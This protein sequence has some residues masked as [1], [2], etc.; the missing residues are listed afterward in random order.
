MKKILVPIDFSPESEKALKYATLLAHQ[1]NAQQ[2]ALYVVED[3]LREGILAH[4]FPPEGYSYLDRRVCA[5]PLEAL[6]HER[7]LDLDTFI[8]STVGSE[9]S[10]RIKKLVRLGKVH[11]E[12]AAVAL[13]ESIDFV[14]VEL[15]RRFPF[16]SLARRRLKMIDKLAYPVLLPPPGGE[17]EPRRGKGVPIFQSLLPSEHSA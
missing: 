14:V 4:T 2:I 16:S 9:D 10:A 17:E 1:F 3:I 6:L 8:A 15:R 13:E 7:S 5:R 12:I 11:K